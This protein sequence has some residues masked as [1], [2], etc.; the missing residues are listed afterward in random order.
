MLDKSIEILFT[1][2]LFVKIGIFII[3]LISISVFKKLIKVVSTLFLFLVLYGWFVYSTGAR[4][5][6]I[7]NIKDKVETL[8]EIDIQ[9]IKRTADKSMKKL[10]KDNKN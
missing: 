4:S 10:K 1:D 9:K 8:N 5:I 2:P 7:E 3:I 6:S